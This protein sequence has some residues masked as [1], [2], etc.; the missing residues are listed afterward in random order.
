MQ[1]RGGLQTTIAEMAGRIVRR[2]AANSSKAMSANR[3]TAAL[4]PLSRSILD[5]LTRGMGV[6][7]QLATKRDWLSAASLAVRDQVMDRWLASKR[8]SQLAGSKDVCYLSLEFLIGRLLRDSANNMGLTETLEASLSELGAGDLVSLADLEADPALG[9]G[10]LG[11]LAACYMES[12]ASIGIPAFGYGIRYDHGL[13]RQLIEDGRQIEEPEAW[14]DGGNPWEVERRDAVFEIGFGGTVE[15]AEGGKPGAWRPAEVI[16]AVAFD[17]PVVG[18]RGRRINSLRLWRARAPKPLR[19]DQFNGGDHIGAQYDQAHA[20]SINKVLYPSDATPAGQELRLRQ[21]YFFAAA[22]MQ[23]LLSRHVERFK[24]VRNLA[25]KVAIQLNDTHPAIAVVELMRLLMDVHG[26]EEADAWSVTRATIS[27]TNHT[28]LPEALESWPVHL[29][30]ALLPRH[31]Q[32]IYA[33]DKRVA[34]DV[35]ASPNGDLGM[36]GRVSLVDRHG[37]WRVRMGNLAFAGARKVNGVSQL[38]TDLMKASVFSDLDRLYPGRIVNKTNGVT[39]RRWLQGVNPGLTALVREAIGDEVLD[40]LGRIERLKPFAEDPVFRDKFKAIKL[41][42]KARLAVLIKDRLGVAVDPNALFDVQIKRIH[43]Y[44]RQLLNLLQIVAQYRAMKENPSAAWMPRVKIFAGKAA[45]SYYAAKQSIHLINDVAAIINTD[46]AMRGLLKVAFIP[47]YNVSLAEVIVP[48]ADL[49]EQI[50]TAG[51]EASGTGNMKLALN[52]AL[53]IGTLDGANVE[54][55]QR[56]GERDIVIFGRT[57]AEVAALRQTGHDPRAN[58]ERSAAL[59]GALDDIGS[60]LFT[61][62]DRD[63]YRGLIDGFYQHDWFM[64]TADFDAYAAAQGAVDARWADTAGWQKSAIRNTAGV[65]WF[66]SDR[67]VREYAADIW[68]ISTY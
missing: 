25:D 17:T 55:R 56:V 26:L 22:S 52:G 6:E 10:G 39:P 50:S 28:L 15:V 30:Q 34:A 7:P 62:G 40:D 64:V 4:S 13:F 9:N 66:S 67:A 23:D 38:H 1:K 48:A 27:Y 37:D 44:K 20:E 11:R 47:N 36:A 59:K 3:D 63:R 41:A 5:E 65:G 32:I 19:L 2:E 8:E 61:G 12:M 51:M 46:P 60:G 21:E 58:I 45:P 42:N 43:E 68:N 18:W 53:T 31:M 33:L 14:L 57:A 29:M 24:N 49:S 35:P 54:I 16:H